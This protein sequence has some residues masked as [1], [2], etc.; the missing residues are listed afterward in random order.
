MFDDTRGYSLSNEPAFLDNPELKSRTFEENHHT[1]NML[2]KI[3]ST[4]GILSELGTR[5]HFIP[6]TIDTQ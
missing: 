1:Q 6:K 3:T 2:N 4:Q 5:P